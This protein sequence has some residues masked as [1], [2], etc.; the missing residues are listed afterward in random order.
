L[1]ALEKEKEK[2]KGKKLPARRLSLLSS[3]LNE[4]KKKK[5]GEGR[6]IP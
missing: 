4:G 1:N 6:R 2:K 3:S 5:E